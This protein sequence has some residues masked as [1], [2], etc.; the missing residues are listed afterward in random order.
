MEVPTANFES[1]SYRELQK[2]GFPPFFVFA[3]IPVFVEGGRVFAV[4]CIQRFVCSDTQTFT[5]ARARSHSH[6]SGGEE[7][8]AARG[9]EE[10]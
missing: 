3:S 7:S 10:A 5:R 1:L 4:S 8:R 9:R 2:V 6:T